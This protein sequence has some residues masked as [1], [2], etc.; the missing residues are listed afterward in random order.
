MFVSDTFAHRVYCK[1]ILEYSE[2]VYIFR[3]IHL[4]SDSKSVVPAPGAAGSVKGVVQ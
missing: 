3:F 4:P 1:I 2:K